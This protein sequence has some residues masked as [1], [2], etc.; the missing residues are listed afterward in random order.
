MPSRPAAGSGPGSDCARSRPPRPR[1]LCLQAVLRAPSPRQHDTVTWKAGQP[2]SR[3]HTAPSGAAP[4]PQQALRTHVHSPQLSG[5]EAEAPRSSWT[6]WPPSGKGQGPGGA[7]FPPHRVLLSGLAPP[8][9][10]PPTIQGRESSVMS[11]WFKRGSCTHFPGA[12]LAA[13]PLQ[14]L[15][16]GAHFREKT[17]L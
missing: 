17:K 12:S 15:L 16:R 4:H 5:K 14:E 8:A 3:L 7:P 10:P 11:P 2:A 6:G 13:R 9:T 1:G